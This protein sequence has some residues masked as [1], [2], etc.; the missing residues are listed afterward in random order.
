MLGERALNISLY[1]E[2]AILVRKTDEKF[3]Q[4]GKS[5]SSFVFRIQA[6]NIHGI[7]LHGA[8]KPKLQLFVFKRKKILI[9]SLYQIHLFDKTLSSETDNTTQWNSGKI[10]RTSLSVNFV[11]LCSRYFL[12]QTV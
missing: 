9:L 8:K 12:S 5:H 2:F 11:Y 3:G 1:V 10:A 7:N 4:I 6:L